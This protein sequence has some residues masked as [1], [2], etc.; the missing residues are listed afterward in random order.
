MKIKGKTY[1]PIG[2]GL[3]Y[4]FGGNHFEKRV[5][6]FK[7]YP[8]APYE[9]CEIIELREADPNSFESDTVM[10]EGR[11]KHNKYFQGKK[12]IKGKGI[13]I[14]QDWEF[15][16]KKGIRCES[17]ELF[18]E[19]ERD[20]I[21]KLLGNEEEFNF[22]RSSREDSYE[23]YQNTNTWIRLTYTETDK[24]NE[25]EFLEGRLKLNKIEIIGYDKDSNDL[26]NDLINIDFKIKRSEDF[27]VCEEKKF[28]FSNSEDMG[29]D[30]NECVYFYTA[31]NIEHLKD[32]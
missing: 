7:G 5:Y 28:T 1:E 24:L 8:Q 30:S 4:C 19:K 2:N 3:G 18:F 21:R 22:S 29:G 31:N 25:I 6:Y 16:P 27:W 23:N 10:G 20:S 15:I 17:V 26:V 13:K 12:I 14:N 11:D 9:R 32:E